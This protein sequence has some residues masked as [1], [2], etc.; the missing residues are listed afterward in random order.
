MHVSVACYAMMD[1]RAPLTVRRYEISCLKRCM[2]PISLQQDASK[3]DLFVGVRHLTCSQH[4]ISIGPS[5]T[6]G[7]LNMHVCH[8]WESPM[9]LLT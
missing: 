9:T 1:R 2:P 6:D 3:H 8:A 5:Q 7:V 4:T